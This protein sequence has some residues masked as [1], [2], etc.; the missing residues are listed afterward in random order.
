MNRALQIGGLWLLG[1]GASFGSGPQA[2]PKNKPAPVPHPVAARPSPP[3][4]GAR[5]GTPAPQAK[6]AGRLVNPGNVATRLFRMTPEERDRVL[7]KLPANQQE[8]ARKTLA[9]FDSLPKE[10]QANQ[11]R[12]LEHFAQLPPERKAEVKQMVMAANQL[13]PP[14]RVA[15]GQ[16]LLRL[17]G[18]TDE[19]REA[20]LNRPAFQSRFSPEEFKIISGLADAWMGPE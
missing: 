5:G 14:R 1:I 15:L 7:E 13:P 10:Q 18:M 8:N 12:R 11:L 20:A 19:Q 6:G 2:A 9:W 17:Q 16:A 4:G 3:K